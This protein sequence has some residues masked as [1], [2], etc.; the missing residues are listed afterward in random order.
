MSERA[1]PEEMVARAFKLPAARAATAATPSAAAPVFPE[2]RGDL[3]AL[4][5]RA[6]EPKS[7]DEAGWVAREARE[8]RE[9]TVGVEQSVAEAEPEGALSL[10]E[11]E[12]VASPQELRL[13]S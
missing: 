3:G 9:E 7:S 6:R 11:Q 5:L 12:E 4:P 10:A 13:V 8:A 1:E 2:A